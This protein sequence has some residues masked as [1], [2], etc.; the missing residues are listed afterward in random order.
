MGDTTFITNKMLDKLS[1]SYNKNYKLL[2]LI[3][4]ILLALSIGYIGYFYFQNGDFIKK[5]VS[6]TGG[7]AVTIF[8]KEKININSLNEYL[9]KKIEGFRIRELTDFKTGKQKAV[10]IESSE[11]SSD[12]SE[13]ESSLE[14]FLGYRLTS[15]NSSIEATGSTLSNSF[16]LQ[17]IY[18]I[19]LSFSFMAI[20][21]LFIFGAE[22]RT[23][24]LCFGMTVVPTFLFFSGLADIYY[25]I[26]LSFGVLIVNVFIYVKNSIPSA[27]V[28]ISAFAD[29]IM[30]LAFVDFIGI[31]VSS[32]GIV[33]FLMLIGYSVDTDVMLTTRLL[34]RKDDTSKS[35]FNAFKTGMTM[36]LTSIV[37]ITTAVLITQSFSEVLRQIFIILLIGLSF[38][39]IN[40]WITNA[41][42]LKWY[43]EK[44]EDRYRQ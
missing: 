34:K 22:W 24:A 27:A 1:E 38:D 39:I 42:I 40:T 14:E 12:S 11:I 17:L 9:S 41:S 10:V 37:A 15:E 33:A 31:R 8:P 18:S 19:V 16:Y 20:V 30:T 43:L 25:A 3:P 7:T 32:A 5:D 36:T 4:I 6:L 26:I 2:L 35:L 44:K 23:K 13:L 29:I 21:V 28:V